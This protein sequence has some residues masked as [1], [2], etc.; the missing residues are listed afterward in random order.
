MTL[1]V[2]TARIEPA[3]VNY[4]VAFPHGKR[5]RSSATGHGEWPHF[6]S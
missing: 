2:V 1:W 3:H 6:S 4:A 5:D